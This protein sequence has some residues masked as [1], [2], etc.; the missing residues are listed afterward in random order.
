[1]SYRSAMA[2]LTLPGLEPL[3]GGWRAF[4]A[5]EP[6]AQLERIR[7]W[8]D[9]LRAFDPEPVAERARLPLG[10]VVASPFGLRAVALAV[11]VGATSVDRETRALLDWQVEG[12]VADPAHGVWE[13]GRLHVGK[14]QA[15]LQD[16]PFATYDPA[17][18]AKW[19]PHELMHRAAGFFWRAG[20]SRFEHYL[21]AR[22]N[23]LLPV[24]LWYGPDQ[25]LRLHEDGFERARAQREAPVSDARW[26]DHTDE[27]HLGQTLRW[28]R[29]GFAHVATE[30]DA[31]DRER[32]SGRCIATPHHVGGAA[33]DASSDALAYVVAHHERLESDPVAEVL[34]EVGAF[35]SVVDYRA[36]VESQWEAL[37]FG[38][39]VLDDEAIDEARTRR[40]AWDQRLRRA[41]AGPDADPDA[42]AADG[43]E[44]FDLGQLYDGVL[45]VAPR[46]ADLLEER[47][48]DWLERF[49]FGPA[50]RQR[51]PLGVR[52]ERFAD[53][54]LAEL[55][56]FEHRLATLSGSDRARLA[57]DDGARIARD[58]GFVL[59]RFDHDVAA[60]HA[61]AEPGP[62]PSAVLLG[63]VGE[64]VAVIPLDPPIAAFWDQLADDA[65]TEDQARES[66]G[67]EWVDALLEAGALVLL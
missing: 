18:V 40:V 50:I 27:D 30:L 45:S 64:E 33:L 59:E 34:A 55:A 49:A 7:P 39:L 44:A 60:L 61:G 2:T 28:L 8:L 57:S 48:P 1:M 36:H 14:Y 19:G 23:E 38:D 25:L 51:A 53:G 29:R 63:R 13:S 32:R 66:L 41:L 65:S 4:A 56:R 17:H 58:D 20:M 67:D 6:E 54:E 9:R 11:Q 15:F 12:A 52:L 26:R 5:L 31:I 22:L 62:G 21:G 16:A 42:I 47:D 43:L 35:D 37:L 10:E 3:D 24:A 46:L